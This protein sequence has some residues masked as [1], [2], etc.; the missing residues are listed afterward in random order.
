MTEFLAKKAASVRFHN[1][2][3]AVS[4]KSTWDGKKRIAKRCGA[5]GAETI[6]ADRKTCKI[7]GQ[8]DIDNWIPAGVYLFDE[9]DAYEKANHLFRKFDESASA[10][11]TVAQ[12]REAMAFFGMRFTDQTMAAMLDGAR[13]N[14][15][16][17]ITFTNYF[18]VIQSMHYACVAPKPGPRVA[19]A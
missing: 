2:K 1:S 3:E 11:I 10:T 16:D 9:M 17:S 13:L 4:F 6:N 8:A 12:L 14:F 15:K 5:C 7:C 19:R 18:L